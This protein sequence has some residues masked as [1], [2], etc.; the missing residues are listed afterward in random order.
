MHKNKKYYLEN[1]EK[2]MNEKEIKLEKNEE[3]NKS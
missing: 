2:A 3:I 1:E